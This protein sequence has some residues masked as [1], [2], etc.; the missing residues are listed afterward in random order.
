MLASRPGAAQT[1]DHPCWKRSCLLL[2]MVTTEKEDRQQCVVT[3]LPHSK[4]VQ[5]VMAAYSSVHSNWY[6]CIHN[7]VQVMS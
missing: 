5:P 2:V 4:A 6:S 1:L 3:E 7:S